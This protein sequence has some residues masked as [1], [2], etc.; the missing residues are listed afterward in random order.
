MPDTKDLLAKR[1]EAYEYI[2]HA[3]SQPP[4][5]IPLPVSD[6][7]LANKLGGAVGLR[8]SIRQLRE[9]THNP[10]NSLMTV[11]KVHIKGIIADS[12]VD[13]HLVTPFKNT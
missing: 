11:F 12:E 9:G 2:I 4:W 8:D 10:T 5:H 3:L 13:A 7:H 6:E 1:K